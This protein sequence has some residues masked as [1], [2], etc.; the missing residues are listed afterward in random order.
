[1]VEAETVHR[2]QIR[3]ALG[4]RLC[5]FPSK[6]FDIKI[7]PL[8]DCAPQTSFRFSRN[9]KIPIDRGEGGTLNLPAIPFREHGSGNLFLPKIHRPGIDPRV[10]SPLINP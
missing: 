6:L 1:M 8:S 7:L 2:P 4:I 10:D 5:E 9:S 3:P